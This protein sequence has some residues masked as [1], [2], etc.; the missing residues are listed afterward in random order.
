M[1]SQRD[2]EKVILDWFGERRG[3]FLDLGAYTGKELSNTRALMERGWAGV[4]VEPNPETFCALMKN[5]EEFE[6]VQ[7]VNAAVAP[8]GGLQ[9]FFVAA[10]PAV[11]TLSRQWINSKRGVASRAIYVH[12]VTM[13]QLLEVFPGPYH[14]LDIDIEGL[15]WP[16]FKT[17]AVRSISPELICIEYRK[18]KKEIT[19]KCERL[20]YK[21][22][23]STGINLLFGKRN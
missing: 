7:L 11:S 18:A 3:R 5:C 4:C 1:Y 6:N 2:E 23:H 9:R 14:F 17:T 13:A 19:A 8:K 20:G 12:C 22:I 16:V 21:R 15:T 10:A